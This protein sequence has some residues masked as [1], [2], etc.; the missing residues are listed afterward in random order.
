[1]EILDFIKIL[2]VLDIKIEDSYKLFNEIFKKPPIKFN[3]KNYQLLKTKF[4]K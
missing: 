1:M 4:N 3:I 2:N